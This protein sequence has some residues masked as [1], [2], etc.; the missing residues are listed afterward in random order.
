MLEPTREFDPK[1]LKTSL[2]DN[3]VTSSDEL[4]KAGKKTIGLMNSNYYPEYIGKYKNN[5]AILN[6]DNRGDGTHWVGIKP[7]SRSV[8][9][10]QDSFGTPPPFHLAGKIIEFNPFVKQ[11]VTEENCGKRA[12]DFVRR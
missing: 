6:L 9:R 10:Y 12:F 3:D 2:K 11:K 7:E 4:F 5:P 1:K 8:Y